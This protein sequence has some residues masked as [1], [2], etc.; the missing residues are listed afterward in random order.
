[1]STFI[2]ISAAIDLPPVSV[3]AVGALIYTADGQYLMQLRDNLPT[4]MMRGYWALFGGMVEPGEDPVRAVIRELRE[5]LGLSL[6]E[7]PRPF[8]QVLYDLRFAGRKLHRK[9]F[10]EVPISLDMIPRLTLHEGQD[11]SLFKPDDLLAQEQVTPW[12]LYG[13]LLHSRRARVARALMPQP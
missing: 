8:S 1:M 11:M 3:L 2:P 5:E 13:V 7:A 9:I 4:V 6:V 12:D 10:F